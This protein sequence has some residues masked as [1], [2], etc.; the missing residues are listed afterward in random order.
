MLRHFHP[1]VCSTFKKNTNSY[2]KLLTGCDE[3]SRHNSRQNVPLYMHHNT[4]VQTSNI[5]NR[6]VSL[7]KTPY[8][9]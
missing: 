5:I 2:K 8:S 9:M 3:L 7:V 6:F 1:T 4:I